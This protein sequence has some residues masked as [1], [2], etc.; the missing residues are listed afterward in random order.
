MADI[1]AEHAP[2][3]I[4]LAL[5]ITG[6][7]EDG[8][9]LLETL[10]VFTQAG[11]RILV[12]RATQD[13]FT[14]TGPFSS[15]L[16]QDGDNLVLRARD[17]ARAL[18]GE[19]AFPVHIELEKNL[20]VASGIGGGSSDAAAVLR[21][22]NGLW[23]LAIAPPKLAQAALSLGADLPMCLAARSLVASGIGEVLLPVA[24]LPSLALVLVNPGIA[25]ATPSV[26]TALKHRNTH[27][28][29]ALPQHRE[30]GMLSGL[31]MGWLA[32][33]RNDLEQPALTIAPQIGTALEALRKE[34][35]VL[36][37]MSGSGAT[38][39]GLFT[40]EQDAAHA[41]TTIAA[42]QPSWYV[43]ATTTIA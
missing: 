2:A 10:V 28:L 4:N 20:P 38:C 23:Q 21:A 27:T 35:A 42:G 12:R 16:P 32:A 11:D 13:G 5:H 24:N 19:C 33:T 6:Q 22:L 8:Y 31:L 9:H 1:I 29:P 3:K 40:S 7:R 39:F 41:A 36:A 18:A 15:N 26:F 43:Q 14:I 30:V 37:R 25:I 17:L 34:G